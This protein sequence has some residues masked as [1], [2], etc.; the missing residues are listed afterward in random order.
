M[1]HESDYK[2][3]LMRELRSS[4]GCV[5][6]RHED[7]FTSGIPDISVTRGGRTSWWEC[8]H[9]NPGIKSEGIQELTMLRL[10]AAGYA[11]YIVWEEVRGILRTLIV[12]PMHIS[13][14]QPETFCR[15]FDMLWLVEQ[16]RKV[17]E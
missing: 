6:L 4:P 3:A 8:K 11:R 12:H 1:K 14:L 10:A 7:R 5:A 13:T 2:A 17:H 15:S 16:I 9:A